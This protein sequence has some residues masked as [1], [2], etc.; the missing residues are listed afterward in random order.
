MALGGFETLVA[1]DVLDFLHPETPL[2]Q[3]GTACV[4][5][6]MPMH[7]FL[8]ACCSSH[9][10]DDLVAMTVVADIRQLFQ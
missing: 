3:K 5:G 4:T 9:L 1:E 8:D 2:I 10:T 7:A 6:Q